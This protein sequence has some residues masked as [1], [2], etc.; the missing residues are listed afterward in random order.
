MPIAA[1]LEIEAA[2][3]HEHATF[4]TDRWGEPID[5]S[6]DGKIALADIGFTKKVITS[7][8][9]PH[10]KVFSDGAAF[11][12]HCA[13]G[14]DG[15][16]STPESRF[17]FYVE[18]ELSDEWLPEDPLCQGE[19]ETDTDAWQHFLSLHAP[20][21]LH[22]ARGVETLPGNAAQEIRCLF[23][24]GGFFG[25][26]ISALIPLSMAAH[27]REVYNLLYRNGLPF[28]PSRH[29]QIAA[30]RQILWRYR[31]DEIPAAILPGRATPI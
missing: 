15:P 19:D 16:D 18:F 8:L 3:F 7:V 11:L 31:P 26:A 30:V 9:E 22:L 29:D 20:A 10:A 2:F 13:P 27:Y 23:D 5:H 12:V 6:L 1:P 25:G 28:P 17:S 14:P 21:L 4:L 24:F